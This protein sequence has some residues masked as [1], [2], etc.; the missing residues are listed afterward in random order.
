MPVIATRSCRRVTAI[1]AWYLEGTELTLEAGYSALFRGLFQFL[2]TNA[3]I[4]SKIKRLPLP[5]TFFILRYSLVTQLF[6][7]ALTPLLSKPK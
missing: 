5:S 2:Q 6:E 4:V 7:G 3:G 1:S